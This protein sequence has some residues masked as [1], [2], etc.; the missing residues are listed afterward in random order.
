MVTSAKTLK[1][2]AT[3]AGEASARYE[4]AVPN[5]LAGVHVGALDGIRGIAILLVL[6]FH[7]GRSADTFG[8]SNSL[9]KFTG[10][11][12][13]GVDLFFVL[14][15]FLITGILYDSRGSANFFRNF[16]ARRALR[17]FPLYYAALLLVAVLSIAWADAGVWPTTSL[18]WIATY[19]T[20]AVMAVEGPNS[21]GI[22]SHYWSLAIEEHFYL[23]WPFVVAS[24]SRRTLMAIAVGMIAFALVLRVLAL[25]YGISTDAIYVLT[26]MRLDALAAGAFCALAVRGPQGIA[27]FVRPAW[28]AALSC[29]AAMALVILLRRSMDSADPYIMTIGYTLLAGAFAGTLIVGITWPFLNAILSNGVLRWFGRYSYGLYVWHVIINV[30]LFYTPVKASLGIDEPA[31]NIAYLF[32]GLGVVLIVAYASYNL[33]EKR[34]LRLKKYFH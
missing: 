23:V 9:L 29:G 20:N 3:L 26:P 2:P 16:Y 8:L 25:E 28:Y 19:L 12:W 11:G 33:F 7:Y 32:F 31:E 1:G 34:L 22:L 13:C 4:D 21:P 5:Q 17:I 6:I 30:L 15:G 24:F 10:I 18:W 14:S 27:P